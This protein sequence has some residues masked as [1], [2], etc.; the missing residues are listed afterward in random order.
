[1]SPYSLL[2]K[3]SCCFIYTLLAL[4]LLPV[5]AAQI[6]PELISGS[7]GYSLCETVETALAAGAV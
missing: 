6:V 4:N 7:L 2:A 5:Y 3:L 1:L